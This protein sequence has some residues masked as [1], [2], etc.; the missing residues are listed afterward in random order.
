VKANQL[1]KMGKVTLNVPSQVRNVIS[2]VIALNVFGGVPLI[3]MAPRILTAINEMTSD[4]KIYKEAQEWGI[5]GGTMSGAELNT[6]RARLDSYL[7]QNNGENINGAFAAARIMAQAF[8]GKTSELYQTTEVVFKLAAYMQAR[9]NGMSPSEAVNHANDALF[10][11]TRVNPNIRYIRNSP[12]GLPFITYLYKVVPKTIQTAV[13]NPMRFAPYLALFYAIPA[14]AMSALGI[15]DDDY[16]AM[17]KSLPEY[18]RDKGSLYIM[19]YRGE[20]GEIKY[21]DLGYFFPW[22]TFVDPLIQMGRG[23]VMGG[24]K[25]LLRNFTPSGPIVTALTALTTNK[26]SFTGRD[27]VDPRQ[28]PENKA[29]A[30]LSYVWNQALPPMLGMDFANPEKSSG[31]LPRLYNDAFGSGTGMKANGQPKPEFL[32]DAGRLLGLNIDTANPIMSRAQNILHMQAQIHASEAL[33]SQIAK[34][35]SLTLEKRRSEI[36]SLNEKIKN[37]YREIQKY[38]QETARAPAAMK[39]GT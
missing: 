26:D 18:I 17:K 35:Q 30:M 2:N 21:A 20:K 36:A 34:D 7:R 22:A 11:Y 4:G 29:L 32:E 15:D 33:R 23:D 13:E 10:D 6:A 27:I 1:W 39:K 38:A 8:I 19:P 12:I 16:E 31:V 9:E 37:D 25:D 28:T 24:G 14:M 3:K 5:G